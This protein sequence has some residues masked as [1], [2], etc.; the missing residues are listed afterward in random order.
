MPLCKS[1]GDSTL[2]MKP[3]EYC[4]ENF[5]IAHLLPE[6]HGCEIECRNAARRDAESAAIA[7]HKARKHVGN[8]EARQALA[9]KIADGEA[10]RRK[11]GPNQQQQQ[12]KRK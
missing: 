3:C 8:D 11:K 9:K 2:G 12:R 6:V 1:C 5:C 7:Q 10:A 4:K